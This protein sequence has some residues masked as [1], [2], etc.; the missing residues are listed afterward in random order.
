MYLSPSGSP[1][2]AIHSVWVDEAAFE[3]HAQLPHTVRFLGSAEKLLTHPVQGLR[4]RQIGEERG[5]ARPNDPQQDKLL[6]TRYIVQKVPVRISVS[7]ASGS[8]AR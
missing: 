5:P 7:H 6:Q 1:S 3:L 2:F 4:L 8:F